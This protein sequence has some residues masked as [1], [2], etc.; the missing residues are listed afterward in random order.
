MIRSVFF[1]SIL[2]LPVIRGGPAARLCDKQMI[3][4]FSAGDQ[5][6]RN[7]SAGLKQLFLIRKNDRLPGW[8][9]QNL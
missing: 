1:Q 6:E 5:E 7:S 8:R 9:I 4:P 3:Q 2:I